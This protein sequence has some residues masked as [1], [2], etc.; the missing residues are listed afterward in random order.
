MEIM[1]IRRRLLERVVEHEVL[2]S[3]MAVICPEYKVSHHFVNKIGNPQLN[4]KEPS[5]KKFMLL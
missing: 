5:N 2:M 3:R 1:D 4:V